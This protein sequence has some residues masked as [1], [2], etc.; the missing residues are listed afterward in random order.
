MVSPDSHCSEQH[1]AGPSSCLTSVRSCPS[2][3]LLS[4]QQELGSCQPCT[5]EPLPSC[6]GTAKHSTDPGN[7][8]GARSWVLLLGLVEGAGEEHPESSLWCIRQ[9]LAVASVAAAL[10]GTISPLPSGNRHKRRFFSSSFR[11]VTWLLCLAQ[12]RVGQ[13]RFLY[14]SC[15]GGEFSS[16]GKPSKVPHPAGRAVAVKGEGTLTCN[17]YPGPSSLHCHPTNILL[18]CLLFCIR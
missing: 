3:L 16:K 11:V 1:L 10:K 15:C 14:K 17:F 18:V 12:H 4:L 13:I 9:S 2:L 5:A 6:Q 7:S 8:A